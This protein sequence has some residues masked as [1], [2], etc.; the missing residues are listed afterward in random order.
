M[1]RGLRRF[2]RRPRREGSVGVIVGSDRPP[3]LIS[4]HESGV[5]RLM[6][7]AEGEAY[8]AY[9]SADAAR[10]DPDAALVME[11]DY[12][13]QIYLACPL[14]VVAADEASLKGLLREL[15]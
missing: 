15:D 3:R 14:R 12:G 7:D 5:R 2:L 11:G 13:G 10:T 9:E 1:F 6:A 4:E 8:V